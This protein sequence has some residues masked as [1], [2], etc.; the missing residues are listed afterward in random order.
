MA[1]TTTGL[2][3][4]FE[5]LSEPDSESWKE[6]NGNGGRN[7]NQSHV[8]DTRNDNHGLRIPDI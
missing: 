8:E 7:T 3:A 4:P 6:E 5:L 2:L 1:T